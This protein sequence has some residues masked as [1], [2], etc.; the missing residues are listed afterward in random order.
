MYSLQDAHTV[1]AVVAL[2]KY[3]ETDHLYWG[4]PAVFKLFCATC[5][6]LHLCSLLISLCRIALWSTH[7]CS[8][9]AQNTSPRLS[10]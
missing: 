5:M 3:L 10:P 1:Q 9:D 7:I 8:N 2:P 6:H 4:D